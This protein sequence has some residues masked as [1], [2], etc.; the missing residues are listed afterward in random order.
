MALKSDVIIFNIIIFHLGMQCIS[1]L[2][3]FCI[4]FRKYGI[5]LL[6]IYVKKYIN[7]ED[8]THSYYID[9]CEMLFCILVCH[10]YSTI[11][12]CKLIKVGR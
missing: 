6:I 10:I 7:H 9:N 1:L 12:L 2:I 3:S 5:I 11:V 4:H 8:A